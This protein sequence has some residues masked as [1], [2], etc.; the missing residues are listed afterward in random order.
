MPKIEKRL[1]EYI[2]ESISN[3]FLITIAITSYTQAKYQSANLPFGLGKTTLAMELAY[4]LNG[5][6]IDDI[7]SDSHIWERVHKI[8]KYNPQEI[9]ELL[10]PGRERLTCAIWDDVQA[11]APSSQSVP[12]A[13][14]ELANFIS[15]ERPECACI[16][17]TCPNINFISAPLRKLVNFEII[18]SERG[19][20]E[21]HKI[22]YHK[23]F[24]HPM[25]DLMSFN[26]VDEIPRL[27]PFPP[28]PKFEQDW[29]N[30]W[31][32]ERKRQLYP[33]L[34]KHLKSYTA[35]QQWNLNGE[36]TTAIIEGVPILGAH[37]KTYLEVPA[38]F[39]HKRIEASAT[40]TS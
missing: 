40:V 31:R 21:V 24:K 26:Y 30:V 8:M 28:L 3:N 25:E 23:D 38:A 33:N 19:F 39:L 15:T 11:T 5:G 18:V 29:Y 9:G 7:Y 6:R 22:S 32:V 13:I 12:S 10:E 1:S 27:E 4:L 36:T 14:R 35:L 16:F 17:F 20:Y 37:G 2:A 34:M